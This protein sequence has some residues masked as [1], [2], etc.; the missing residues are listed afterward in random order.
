MEY[1]HQYIDRIHRLSLIKY[2]VP[3]NLQP[4]FGSLVLMWVGI[5]FR[6][7]YLNIIGI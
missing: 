7:Q 2:D 1:I 5:E 3:N 6:D 4:T